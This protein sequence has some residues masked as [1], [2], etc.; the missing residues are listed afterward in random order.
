MTWAEFLIR[1]HAYHR[2]EKNEWYKVREMAYASLI[3]S[4]VDP[5]KLP[6]SKDKFIPLDNDV[7]NSNSISEAARKAILKAQQEY[8]KVQ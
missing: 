7:N 2:I 4:H 5:K 3:G 8:N 6:K 1:Q